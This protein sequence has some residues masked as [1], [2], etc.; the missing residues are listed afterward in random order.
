[1]DIV[2]MA[3][4]WLMTHKKI[5]DVDV[6]EAL[7]ELYEKYEDMSSWFWRSPGKSKKLM[8]CLEC[9]PKTTK[10]ER[11]QIFKDPSNLTAGF[12]IFCARSIRSTVENVVD[13]SGFGLHKDIDDYKHEWWLKKICKT[14]NDI[15]AN[16][17]LP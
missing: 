6:C 9:R 11:K 7:H 12:R 3:I 5:N 16:G 1:M 10:A 8:M 4:N 2:E 14:A 17:E 13:V 15:V